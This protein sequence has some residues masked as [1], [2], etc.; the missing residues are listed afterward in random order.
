V[1]GGTLEYGRTWF[2]GQDLDDGEAELHGS[3][4][5]GFD[6]WIG[7]MQLGYGIREGGDGVFLLE[8]GRPR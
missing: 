1:L 2:A 5:F 8:L 6:S 4:Y 3:L 7:P